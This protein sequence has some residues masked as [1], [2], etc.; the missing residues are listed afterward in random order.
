MTRNKNITSNIKVELIED[1]VKEDYLRWFCHIYRG[2]GYVV[3]RIS[4]NV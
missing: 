4:G 1:K 2:S 3:I